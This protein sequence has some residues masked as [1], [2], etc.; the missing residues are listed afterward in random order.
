MWLGR[1]PVLV[2]HYK[3][4]R[5][6]EAEHHRRCTFYYFYAL[7]VGQIEFGERY[8]NTVAVV[9]GALQETAHHELFVVAALRMVGLNAADVLDHVL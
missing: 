1:C 4:A 6:A 5:I 2:D 3:A 9:D 8:P 7:D